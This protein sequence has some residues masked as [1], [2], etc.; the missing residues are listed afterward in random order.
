MGAITV[1][2]CHFFVLSDPK[3]QHSQQRHNAGSPPSDIVLLYLQT[4]TCADKFVSVALARG[5]IDNLHSHTIHADTQGSG[6]TGA[7][8]ARKGTAHPC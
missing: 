1:F 8:I 3:Q 7:H 5:R 4:T 2:P 6:T